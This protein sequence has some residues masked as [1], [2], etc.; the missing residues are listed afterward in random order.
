[1]K[2]RLFYRG[3][4]LKDDHDLT[5]RPF[6]PN[7]LECGIVTEQKNEEGLIKALTVGILVHVVKLQPG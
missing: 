6:S 3:K 7:L 1:M 5:C 4:E 2:L